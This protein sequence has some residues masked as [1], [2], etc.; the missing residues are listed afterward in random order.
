MWPFG[1]GK[2]A[3]LVDQ[4]AYERNLA[5]QTTMAPQT[6]T[7]L[8]EAGM[9]PRALLR[10]EYFFYA[11]SRSNGDALA[12][13]LLAKGYS[14]ECRP[15]ADGSPLFCITGWSTPFPIDE[16]SAV[17]WTTEMCRLGYAHDCEF[18]GWGTNPDQPD[19]QN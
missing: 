6:V 9:Q 4:A 17:A 7:Q 3:R 15:A 18:D 16:G 8:H 2:P 13:D 14:S 1:K 11:A 19:L 10:L 12:R 5:S